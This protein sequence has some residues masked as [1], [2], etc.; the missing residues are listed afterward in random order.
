MDQSRSWRELLGRIIGDA[1]ERQ[2]IATM[3]GINPA[4]LTRWVANET[5]PRPQNLRELLRA[6]PNQRNELLQLIQREFPEFEADSRILDQEDSLT[7]IPPAFYSRVLDAFI[8]TRRSQRFWTVSNLVLNQALG[9]LDPNGLGMA[10]TVA[11]CVPPSRNGVVRS[12][13]EVAGSG[14]PPWQSTLRREALFLGIESLAGYAVTTGR[15]FTAEN[16]ADHLGFYPTRWEEWEE[17]AAVAPIWFEY[18]IAGCL[19][20]SSTQPKY[21]LP[22]RQ[23]LV[24]Q[25]AK[26]IVLAFEPEDFY[27]LQDIQL[28]TMPDREVQQ[29]IVSDFR[30]RLSTTLLEAGRNRQAI[31]IEQAERLVW[32]QLEEELIE[33]LVQSASD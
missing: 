11:Q 12:M 21:F 33:L 26:L 4:T 9:H 13:R 6:L 30:Q 7:T 16:R 1:H 19:V 32:Q 10:I 20:A 24:E 18:R 28:L 2:R 29:A 31:D 27:A 15:A 8:M 23:H 17:S 22:Y 3:L 25:Y 5:N 14:T